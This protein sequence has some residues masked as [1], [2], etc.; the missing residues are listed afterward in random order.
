MDLQ[1]IG[2]KVF[3]SG[4]TS[5]IGLCVAKIFL[6]EGA[7]V[8][9][10]GR[11][12][13]RVLKV[14]S[15]LKEMYPESKVDGFAADFSKEEEV[16]KLIDHLPS[17]DI[18]INNVGIYSSQSFFDTSDE[19]W[20]RQ[21]VVNVMA[22]VRLS[23]TFL[24]KMLEKNWGRIIFVSSEC[25]TLVPQDLIAY[26]TTKAAILAVSRGL[27]QLTKGSNVT[28]NS[29]LPGST[30]TEGAKKFISELAAQENKTIDQAEADFFKNARPASLLQR[31]AS[32]EEIARTIVYYAS[33]LASATNGAAIKLDGGSM[34]GII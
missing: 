30:G 6:E 28:V 7:E 17:V 21:F 18:L 5:G 16:K 14:V 15:D 13:S 9:I 1:L 33:P 32:E 25:A 4:S 12:N 26:S 10:N 11:E 34:G 2:K 19:E 29:V 27:S 23:R 8:Y 22:G 3:I 31:F 20:M 24:P